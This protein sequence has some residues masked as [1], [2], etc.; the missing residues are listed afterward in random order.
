MWLWLDMFSNKGEWIILAQV[1]CGSYSH[2]NYSITVKF[3]LTKVEDDCCNKKLKSKGTKI[4]SLFCS[5]YHTSPPLSFYL[6][7]ST[8]C[9]KISIYI[10]VPNL[11]Q[12]NTYPHCVPIYSITLY[13]VSFIYNVFFT[14]K[15]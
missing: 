8:L 5:A 14:V 9:P 6:F 11:F 12:L 4:R 2:H 7:Y 13:L 3:W 15:V 10:S 1:R